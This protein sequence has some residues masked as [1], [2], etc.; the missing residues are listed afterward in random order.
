M[1]KVWMPQHV[2]CETL[3]IIADVLESTG[4]SAQYVRTFD[5]YR[6]P[7]RMDDAVGL[8]IMGGP[9]GVL[10]LHLEEAIRLYSS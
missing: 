4:V 1:A 7:E 10:A 6:V 9:M 5:D 2:P 3:G 8:V